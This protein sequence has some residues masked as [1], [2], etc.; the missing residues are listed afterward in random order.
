[1]INIHVRVET[2]KLPPPCFSVTASQATGRKSRFYQ[3]AQSSSAARTLNWFPEMAG[4]QRCMMG[5]TANESLSRRHRGSRLTWPSPRWLAY[6]C[7]IKCSAHV[8]ERLKQAC[9]QRLPQLSRNVEA[10][11]AC[12]YSLTINTSRGTQASFNRKKKSKR[13]KSFPWKDSIFWGSGL[14]LCSQRCPWPICRICMQYVLKS[15]YSATLLAQVIH[16][17]ENTFS[18]CM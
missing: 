16:F 1:M 4:Q 14:F 8:G 5:A 2:P 13:F 17:E 6:L 11:H 15:P 10:E 7:S 12:C 18:C 3:A 9:G